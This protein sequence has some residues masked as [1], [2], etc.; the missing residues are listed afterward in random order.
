MDFKKIFF[1]IIG[2]ISTIIG[3]IGLL[4][5][6]FPTSPFLI[7]AAIFFAKGSE[8][9]DSWLKN[10]RLYEDYIKEFSKE[11][12]MTLKR[13]IK[14]LV[15]T[16]LIIAIPFVIFDNLY[17]WGGLLIIELFKYYYFIFK[18]KTKEE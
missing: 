13:K 17:L 12:S 10:T 7:L 2:I 5:P 16:D 9:F 18:I 1:I 15:S 6:V 11:R 3:L 8:R 14:I 4:I